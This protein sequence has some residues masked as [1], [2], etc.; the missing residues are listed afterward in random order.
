MASLQ[1]WDG[2]WHFDYGADSHFLFRPGKMSYFD[3][4]S[5][6]LMQ[7]ADRLGVLLFLRGDVAVARSRIAM[8]LPESLLNAP[9]EH[10]SL[11]PLQDL[12]WESRVGGLIQPAGAPVPADYLVLLH[13]GDKVE[14]STEKPI[15]SET[16][17][18]GIDPANAVLTI[19]TPR[20]AGGFANAGKSIDAAKAGVRIDGVTTDA[21]VFVNSLDGAPIRSSKRLLV[22]HLTDLQNT[23]A[24]FGERARQTL[25]A[26]GGPPH[27]VLDGAATVHVALD[28]P[29]AYTVWALATSGK[30]LEKIDAKTDGG[31][32]TFTAS[33]RGA[34]G[35][36]MLYE[37]AR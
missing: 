12:V 11:S 1:D 4:V 28:D 15:R 22:T 10:A 13:P 21:T 16:G 17:E 33:V 30:R 18:I 32:L 7:A 2:L 6:P 5:D 14:A 36:R 9:R 3:L 29:S 20:S 37:I 35:A 8:V 19:D 26:W 31:Q 23:G 34:D 25:Q 24:Q 27:L